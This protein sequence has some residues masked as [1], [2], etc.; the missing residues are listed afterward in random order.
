MRQ[1]SPLSDATMAFDG[2]IATT[3]VK[4]TS[5]SAS[6]RQF[7]P[8]S[9]LCA[10]LE[11]KVESLCRGLEARAV[12]FGSSIRQTLTCLVPTLHLISPMSNSEYRSEEMWNTHVT[13]LFPIHAIRLIELVHL[14]LACRI[15][16]PVRGLMLH[17]YK[18]PSLAVPRLA[19]YCES[20]LNATQRTPKV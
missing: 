18:N 16:A 12:E 8:A 20:G 1:I 17:T 5:R 7:R 3:L 19:R 15:A 10:E 9:V 13:R 4:V 11:R 6:R 2:P 14:L